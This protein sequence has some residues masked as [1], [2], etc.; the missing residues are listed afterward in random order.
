MPPIGSPMT[1]AFFLPFRDGVEIVQIKAFQNL[2]TVSKRNLSYGLRWG[3]N[4]VCLHA[5]I[6]ERPLG[7]GSSFR[8]EI[9]L[10]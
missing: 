5:A 9:V 2:S 6:L 7:V 3:K 10:A 1:F 8:A 4:G